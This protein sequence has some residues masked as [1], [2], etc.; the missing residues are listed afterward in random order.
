[1]AKTNSFT[2]PSSDGV[3]SV[4][5]FLWLPEGEARGIVH[6]I[7]GLSEYTERYDRFARFLTAQGFIV[8]G[9]DHLGHGKTASDKVFGWF[10]EKDGWHKVLTD[11]RTMHHTIKKQYPHLPYFF[12]G[13]SMGSFLGRQYMIDYPGEIDGAIISGTGQ[14]SLPLL[15][16]GLLLSRFLV[17]I[18]KGKQISPIVVALSVGAFNK[19]FKPN[20]TN[21]D[22]I[23]RDEAVQDAYLADRFCRFLPAT[24][25]YA[26]MIGGMHYIGIPKN[27]AKVDK[28]CPVF[29]LSGDKDPVGEQGK[30]VLK[31]RDLYLRAGCTD[32]SCKLYP[33]GRHEMLNELNYEEVH[34]DVLAWLEAHL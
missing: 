13:H 28:S 11:V 21:V 16:S 6:I 4:C 5:A 2:F 8:C 31:A 15:V 30:G 1:M 18:G 27:V 24:S 22:W 12:F 7:H 26:D 29:L 10:A 17:L 9:N 33:E 3:H 34:Q 23:S 19:K 20:R 14:M 32:I 25:M